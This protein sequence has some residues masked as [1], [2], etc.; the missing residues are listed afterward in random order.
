MIANLVGSRWS[1][2]E[3]EI[4]PSTGSAD[5]YVQILDLTRLASFAARALEGESDGLCGR[6]ARFLQR[7]L[8][9]PHD[10][11]LASFRREVPVACLVVI[12]KLDRDS[13]PRPHVHLYTNLRS[14]SRV[15]SNLLATRDIEG[16]PEVGTIVV[17][18]DLHSAPLSVLAVRSPCRDEGA[19]T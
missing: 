18:K 8:A 4:I 11:N 9:T 3:A 10:P 12:V 1:R 19:A 14:A 13:C 16:S 7:R 15:R 6:L 17:S 5:G 2:P